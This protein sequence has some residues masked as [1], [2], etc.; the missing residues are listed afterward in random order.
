MQKS[1]AF[2]TIFRVKKCHFP[3]DMQK[4]IFCY[5]GSTKNVVLYSCK[6]AIALLT[7]TQ[8]STSSHAILPFVKQRI[9]FNTCNINHYFTTF[10]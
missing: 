8:R 2:I 6:N 9:V 1:T 10:V 5:K 7:H 4:N 3:Y